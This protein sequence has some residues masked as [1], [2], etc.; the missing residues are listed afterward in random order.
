MS[1]EVNAIPQDSFATSRSKWLSSIW[2]TWDGIWNAFQKPS[3]HKPDTPI[4]F[5]KANNNS[6]AIVD[7]TIS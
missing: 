5:K 4:H 7:L 6:Q 1:A 2:V 3:L